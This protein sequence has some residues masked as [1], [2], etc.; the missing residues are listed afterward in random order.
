MNATDV[1][2]QGVVLHSPVPPR[3]CLLCCSLVDVDVLSYMYVC[4]RCVIRQCNSLRLYMFCPVPQNF[5]SRVLPLFVRLSGLI[6]AFCRLPFFLSISSF[7]VLFVF[8]SWLLMVLCTKGLIRSL[9]IITRVRIW[10]QAV[11]SWPSLVVVTS[12]VRFMW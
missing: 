4:A 8:L 6:S 9:S 2:H 10:C 3:Y 12:T 7:G 11:L 1:H 5:I